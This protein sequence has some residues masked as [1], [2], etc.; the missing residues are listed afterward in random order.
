MRIPFTHR[1]ISLGRFVGPLALAMPKSAVVP[2]L[3]GPARGIRWLVGS[4]MPNFWLGTYEREKYGLF[5]PWNDR[6]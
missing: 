1:H 4:G 2:I 5:S 3:Q 6:V